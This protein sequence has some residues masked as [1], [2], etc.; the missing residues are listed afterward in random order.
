M[1]SSGSST[2]A[3]F[4]QPFQAPHS[5]LLLFPRSFCCHRLV[6]S[7]TAPSW[8]YLSWCEWMDDS[9]KTSLIKHRQACV[10]CKPS[11]KSLLT[12]SRAPHKNSSKALSETPRDWVTS[13][14]DSPIF[15]STP[16]LIASITLGPLW[17]A[18][19]TPA[20]LLS[21]PCGLLP[22][23]AVPAW[24]NKWNGRK[25]A[26]WYEHETST[27]PCCHHSLVNSTLTALNGP[28]MHLKGSSVSPC[29]EFI[30]YDAL[31]GSEFSNISIFHSQ[32]HSVVHSVARF[33][34]FCFIVP[35]SNT[36][37]HLR[38]C[39]QIVWPFSFPAHSISVNDT[40]LFWFC[41]CDSHV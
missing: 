38:M 39:W 29:R 8:V 34:L 10:G 9:G 31:C 32:A 3:I 19:H 5:A 27:L 40:T 17:P 30:F 35:F 22:R 23:P 18:S 4:R 1:I 13:A 2:V 16:R 11:G 6:V 12:S 37:T 33:I 21:S 36:V 20:P 14:L 41:F 28:F 25:R 15:P 26:R 24:Q 7:H